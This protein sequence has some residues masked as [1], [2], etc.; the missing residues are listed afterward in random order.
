MLLSLSMHARRTARSPR[1][2]LPAAVIALGFTSFF[3]DVGSEMV[4]PLLPAFVVSLGGSATFFGLVEGLADAVAGLLKLASGHLVD[5]AP[6]KKPFVLLGYGMAALVRPLVALATA[7]W[8][9]LAVRLTDR[10]GKGIRSAPRDVLLAEAVSKE[11]SGR[12][13]GF[14]RAMDHAG[15]VVGP[16]LAT[17][18]LALGLQVRTVFW[19]ALVP[20]LLSVLAVL[21]V[22]EK[23]APPAAP[24]AEVAEVPAASAAPVRLPA[25]LRSYLGILVLFALGNS[26]DAFL[27]LRARD[28]GVPMGA[29]PL[30][31][32]MFHVSKLVSSYLGGDLADRV[33]RPRLIVAGWALYALTYLAFGVATRPWQVWALFL[34]YGVYYGLTEPAEKALVKDLAPATARGRAY[35]LYNFLVGVCAVPAGVLTGALWQRW[36]ASLALG[37]GAGIAA[38]AALAMLVWER[39]QARLDL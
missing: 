11:D 10:V 26:P 28:L 20:G 1:A 21:A 31:W 32:A 27:L 30:L 12:A 22:R 29:L 3:T 4:F 19:L 35:G 23:S 14:H 16:L 6:A 39:R 13:F 2:P 5:R 25:A 33:P 18:L 34:V 24:L 7:P 36:G 9:V 38:A 17:A 37:V 8:H 15:A